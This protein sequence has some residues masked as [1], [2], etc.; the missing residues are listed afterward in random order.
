MLGGGAAPPEP[1][2]NTAAAAKAGSFDTDF[3]RSST[4]FITN[5]L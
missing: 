3:S 1:D 5:T 4:A 2:N